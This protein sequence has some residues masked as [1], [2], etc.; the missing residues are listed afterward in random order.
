MVDALGRN[1]RGRSTDSRKIRGEQKN[2]RRA[3][4]LSKPEVVSDGGKSRT[5]NPRWSKGE[6]KG[7]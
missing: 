7:A 1:R 6:K 2:S 5:K 3:R 4:G